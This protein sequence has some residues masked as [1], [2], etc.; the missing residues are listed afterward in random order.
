M[1][2]S[3]VVVMGPVLGSLNGETTYEDGSSGVPRRS[4]TNAM[5]ASLTLAMISDIEPVVSITKASVGPTPKSCR[6]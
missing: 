4:V 5:L 3:E 1:L 6:S 2:K